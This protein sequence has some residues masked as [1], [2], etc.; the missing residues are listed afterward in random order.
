LAC[1]TKARH[2]GDFADPL[3]NVSQMVA[4]RGRAE[5]LPGLDYQPTNAYLPPRAATVKAAV[6]S[7]LQALINKV[8]SL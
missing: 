4:K 5:M 6:P 8:V 1:P 7:R 2:F 3:S